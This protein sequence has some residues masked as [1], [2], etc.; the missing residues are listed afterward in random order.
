MEPGACKLSAR[1]ATVLTGARPPHFYLPNFGDAVGPVKVLCCE[2]EEFGGGQSHRRKLVVTE[3]VEAGGL[4]FVQNPLVFGVV[5]EDGHLERLGDALVTAA[6]TSPRAAALAGLLADDGQ[7]GED[8]NVVATI[9]DVHAVS[10]PWTKETAVL[11]V[12]KKVVER[13]SMFTGKSYVGIWTLPGMARHSCYPS[14][15]FT[16]FGD[17]YIARASRTLKAGDEV[18]FSFWDVLEPLDNR[19]QTATEKCGGFWCRCPRCEAEETFGAKARL[20]SETMQTKFTLN[21]TRVTA[22]KEQ[23]TLQIES[24][25]KDMEKRFQHHHS[26]DMKGYRNGLLGLADRFRDLNGRTLSDEELVEVREFLPEVN[27]PEMVSVPRDLAKE[28]LGAVRKFEDDLESCNLNEQQRNWFVA[29]HLNYYSEVL[30]LAVLQKDVNAQRF[31]VQSMLSAVAATAPG[32]FIHQR[33]AVFNWEVAVQCE[34][35]SLSRVGSDSDP[36]PEEKELA[37]QALRLRYGMDL[38]LMEMEAAMARTACSRDVDE[39]W[40]WEVSWCI[41]MAP[42]GPNTDIGTRGTS[43]GVPVV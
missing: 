25:K 11:D 5:E 38:S 37:R 42:R 30:V 15:N 23:L 39:N 32:S 12:C 29:S 7:L 17:S 28:L 9:T 40:C 20:A 18:T 31:L 16:C 14:A 13:S 34:D 3:D 6:T 27:A 36:A 41:G 4:L 22:I 26:D 21:V 33:L 24:K 8:N 35:P 43:L 1:P 10:E 19:R 2:H